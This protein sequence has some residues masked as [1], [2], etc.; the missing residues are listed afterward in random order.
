[1]M[2]SFA[3]QE[4]CDLRTTR[5]LEMPSL[6][7][8]L[9][10]E[11]VVKHE[12]LSVEGKEVVFWQDVVGCADQC[13]LLLGDKW[14]HAGIAWQGVSEPCKMRI[15]LHVGPVTISVVGVAW[16]GWGQG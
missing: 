12:M 7:G 11:H 9:C 16:Y 15:N 4:G 10:A 1:M 13:H 2:L 14:R 6:D 8:L 5:S 3:Q